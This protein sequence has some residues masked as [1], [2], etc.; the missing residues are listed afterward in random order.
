MAALIYFM[1]VSVLLAEY[2]QHKYGLPRAVGWL[3]ELAS[4]IAAVVVLL[5]MQGERLKGVDARYIVLFVLLVIGIL[6]GILLN[7][8]TPGTAVSGARMYFKSLP[9]FVLPLIVP[10]TEKTLKRQLLLMA[11]LCII[12]L[13]IAWQ[14]RSHTDFVGA[15]TGDWI[16]GTLYGPAFLSIFLCSGAAVAFA[17]YLTGRLSFKVLLV[18]FALT[19]PATMINETKGTLLLLPLALL[20]P[21]IFAEKSKDVAKTNRLVLS[22]A[23]ISTF[24]A[25]FIPVYDH[26]IR[27]RW[28][29]GLIE[30]VQMQGRV[31]D[32]LVKNSNL[33]SQK[34][35]KL[36]SILLPFKA[37]RHDPTE[38]IVGLGIG[39][40]SE[41]SFGPGF[42]GEHFEQYGRLMG[43][44]VSLL[45]WEI[46]LFGTVIVLLTLYLIFRDA[47]VARRSKGLGGAVALGWTGVLAITVVGMFYKNTLNS[48]ALGYLFWFYSGV[49]V[50][51]ASEV[52]RT[53]SARD[54][55]SRNIEAA[56]VPPVH[57]RIRRDV[58]G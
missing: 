25:I 22:I 15:T 51:L 6:A 57:A 52:R 49:V 9:F 45:L 13:P 30:F 58:P 5:R 39:N 31:E 29:Y 34:S 10:V 19:L 12:Q 23:L 7:T 18:F 46:G 14:Q 21:A 53:S 41:S 16:V 44:T 3:P 17:M 8:L 27:A 4:L 54:S 50:A 36:D 55:T 26:Y 56:H 35:G 40:V 42:T 32:Y 48:N 38:A 20:V 24:V 33:G 1:T 2:L 11:I 37:A 47:L 43:P 28:G